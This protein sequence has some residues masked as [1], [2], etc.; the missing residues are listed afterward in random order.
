[1]FAKFFV[2]ELGLM[3][4]CLLSNPQKNRVYLTNHGVHDGEIG[5]LLAPSAEPG[6][7]PNVNKLFENVL[8]F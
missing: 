1:M 4:A 5:R 6:L 8:E 2:F 7:G 3:V